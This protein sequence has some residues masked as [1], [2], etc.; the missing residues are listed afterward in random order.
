MVISSVI[1]VSLQQGHGG[2][3]KNFLVLQ[4]FEFINRFSVSNF[5][6]KFIPFMNTVPKNVFLKLF[7]RDGITFHFPA[8]IDLKE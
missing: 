1:T 7:V 8:D 5:W 3:I 4:S 6:F 2:Y